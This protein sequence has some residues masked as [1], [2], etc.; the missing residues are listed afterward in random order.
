[1][2]LVRYS[3]AVALAAACTS[4]APEAVDSK[5]PASE[6]PSAA[7]TAPAADSLRGIIG[8]RGRDSIP[9]LTLQRSDDTTL[10]RSADIETLRRVVGFEVTVRGT[11]AGTSF[12]VASFVLHSLDGQRVTDGTL[13]V[14]NGVF[15]V[16]TPDGGRVSITTIP[17]ALRGEI[18]S[19]VYL[20][21][22]LDRMP[23]AFGVITEG[24]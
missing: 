17:A 8:V 15:F 6:P 18:G 2:H 22:P 4:K 23:S 24:R 9:D 12:D 11:R 3:F 10:L 21:G 1:M 7:T 14:E 19:R 16:R 5:A 20:V 13:D